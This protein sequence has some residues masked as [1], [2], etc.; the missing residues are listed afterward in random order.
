MGE[1]SY[2]I[3]PLCPLLQFQAIIYRILGYCRG[4]TP[5][6]DNFVVAAFPSKVHCG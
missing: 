3:I 2:K 1:I 6:P 5:N 4:D